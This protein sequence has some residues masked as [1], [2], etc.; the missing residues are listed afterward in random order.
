MNSLR[1]RSLA[2]ANDS[3]VRLETWPPLQSLAAHAHGTANHASASSGGGGRARGVVELG[4][5]VAQP[6]FLAWGPPAVCPALLAIVGPQA[7]EVVE[8]TP[9]ITGHDLRGDDQNLV[10]LSLAKRWVGPS[11]HMQGASLAHSLSVWVC[12]S[13]ASFRSVRW[14]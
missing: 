6:L 5:G 7:F 12:V 8:V 4:R 1:Y 14:A 9:R 11:P 2:L 10:P 3:E 13:A